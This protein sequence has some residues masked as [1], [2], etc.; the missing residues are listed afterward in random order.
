MEWCLYA[1]THQILL[2]VASYH[3]HF[4]SSISDK[5][6]FLKIVLILL[7]VNWPIHNGFVSSTYFSKFSQS[8]PEGVGANKSH[9][10]GFVHLPQCGAF[11]HSSIILW[12]CAFVPGPLLDVEDI[13]VIKR[14]GDPARVVEII[15]L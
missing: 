1:Y 14:D 13:K 5:P 6:G 11:N 7:A 4:F 12:I 8:I 9:S 15:N 2:R 10:F 3:L